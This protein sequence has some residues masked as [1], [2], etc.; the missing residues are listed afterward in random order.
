MTAPPRTTVARLGARLCEQVR[1]VA[2]L[3]LAIDIQGARIAQMERTT[4]RGLW[5]F[6]EGRPAR[7]TRLVS[8]AQPGGPSS[9]GRACR[10]SSG[11]SAR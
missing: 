5:R 3:Q 11:C 9:G 1:E 7:A 4:T 10:G 8:A 6:A 2:S